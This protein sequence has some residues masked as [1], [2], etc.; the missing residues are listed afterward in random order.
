MLENITWGQFFLAVLVGVLIWAFF[1]ARLMFESKMKT[2]EVTKPPPRR[3]H[4]VEPDEPPEEEEP[5]FEPEYQEEEE[6]QQHEMPAELARP[7]TEPAEPPSSFVRLEQ[8]A[9]EIGRLVAVAGNG[10]DKTVLFQNLREAISG[11]PDL[12]LPAF[13]AA[14]SNLIARA[15]EKECGY[16][17][18]RSEADQLWIS[19]EGSAS[20]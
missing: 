15:I 5:E 10:Q 19:F 6:E 3:W 20:A 1:L 16:S 7:Q 4:P 17:I 14:I 13:R 2:A 11:Y 8:L 12:N 9:D 18:S